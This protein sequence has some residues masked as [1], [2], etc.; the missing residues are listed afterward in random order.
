MK[1]WKESYNDSLFYILKCVTFFS[2]VAQGNNSLSKPDALL[3][4]LNQ[5]SLKL[6]ALY[7]DKD[8]KEK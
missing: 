5:G 3:G 8:Q 6:K 2:S 4:P 1:M 7:S